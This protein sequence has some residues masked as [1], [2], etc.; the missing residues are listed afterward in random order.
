MKR[1]IQTLSI[2]ALG[3]AACL[4]SSTGN[5]SAQNPS[6]GNFNPSQMRERMLQR[7]REQLEV[8][9]DSEWTLI[10]ARITKVMDARRADRKSVV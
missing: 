6:Q 10:S 2:G 5:V 9:E 3:T 8:K 7:V 4:L 1:L